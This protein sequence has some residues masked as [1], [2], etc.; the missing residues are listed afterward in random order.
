MSR[1]ITPPAYL[2]FPVTAEGHQAGVTLH[3][4]PVIRRASLPDGRTVTV[5]V[6]L[7]PDPYVDPREMDT[8]VLELSQGDDLLGT[9]ETPLS[10]VDRDEALLLA[11]RVRE[12]LESGALEPTAEGVEQ[13][14]LTPPAPG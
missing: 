1:N 13:V 7:L 2:R 14:A 6:A 12:G 3:D 5:R 8:V 11:D 4:S 9:V 10:A